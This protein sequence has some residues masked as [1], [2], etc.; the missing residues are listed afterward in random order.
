MRATQSDPSRR[1]V[2]RRA[3]R[4]WRHARTPDASDS[5]NRSP[6]APS[7]WTRTTRRRLARDRSPCSCIRRKQ[8]SRSRYRVPYRHARR[9]PAAARRRDSARDVPLRGRPAAAGTNDVAHAALTLPRHAQRAPPRETFIRFGSSTT[10]VA[11]GLRRRVTTDAIVRRSRV[12]SSVRPAFSRSRNS[13]PRGSTA[14]CFCRNAGVT[15]G[16]NLGQSG[17]AKLPGPKE[18]GW[19]RSGGRASRSIPRRRRGGIQRSFAAL[20]PERETAPPHSGRE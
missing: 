12:T 7:R 2:W 20:R 5:P 17:R 4:R 11:L 15:A 6:I 8:Q 13:A 16:R 1:R 19:I 18:R 3:H 10:G 9:V 14:R